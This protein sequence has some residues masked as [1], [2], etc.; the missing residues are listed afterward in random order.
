MKIIVD[1]NIVFSGILNSNG[2]IGDLLINSTKYFRFIA[3][4]FLRIEI[5]KHHPRLCKIS[6]MNVE[7]V[8]EAQLQVCKDI[9]FIS[10]EQI[11]PGFWSAAEKIVADIDPKDTHYIAYSKQFRCKIWS[12]DKALMRGLS[13]KGFTNFITTEEL[14][15][16]RQSLIE[17]V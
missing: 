13:K 8:K 10:E 12:G 17:K 9:N 6:G 14:F 4:D 1:A 5:D 7:V 16:L 11:K 15:E 3:P 2:K